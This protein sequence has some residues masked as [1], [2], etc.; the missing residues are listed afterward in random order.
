MQQ[1][2]VCGELHSLQLR[3]HGG[4]FIEHLLD[5]YC[6]NVLKVNSKLRVIASTT[7]IP[8][9]FYKSFGQKKTHCGHT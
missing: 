5:F 9:F 7:I 2:E 6:V 8:F 3:W 1:G 4:H